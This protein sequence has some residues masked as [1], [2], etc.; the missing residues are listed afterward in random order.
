MT[1][2]HAFAAE[3]RPR[4]DRGSWRLHAVRESESACW[5]ELLAAADLSGCDLRVRPLRR[6]VGQLD[7]RRFSERR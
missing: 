7:G 5:D 3:Y 6:R 4:G 1:T 2:P